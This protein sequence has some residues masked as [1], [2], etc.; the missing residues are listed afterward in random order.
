MRR[1]AGFVS[2]CLLLLAGACH[3]KATVRPTPPPPVANTRIDRNPLP[4]LPAPRPATPPAPIPTP[5]PLNLFQKGE[6]YF[7]KGE[8]DQA[9]LAFEQYLKDPDPRNQPTALFHMGMARILSADSAK[10]M[11]QAEGDLKSLIAQ[12]PDSPYRAQAEF[13]LSQ[14]SQIDRLRNDVKERDEKIRE[15]TDELQKLKE[16]DMQRRPSRPPE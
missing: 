2:I 13:I 1:S 9:T 3:R 4:S 7:E 5:V 10:N 14:Q 6:Q 16:I 11:R 12:F 15:L 8:Y